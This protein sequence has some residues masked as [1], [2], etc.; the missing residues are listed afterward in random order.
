MFT[1][2]F[3]CGCSKKVLENVQKV[4]TI[5]CMPAVCILKTKNKTIPDDAGFL[6]GKKLKELK[7]TTGLFMVDAH[8]LI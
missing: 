1:C 6:T 2:M 4:S 3:A 7:E 8:A 5:T